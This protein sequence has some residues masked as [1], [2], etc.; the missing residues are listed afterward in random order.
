MERRK[1]DFRPHKIASVRYVLDKEAVV[2]SHEN[3]LYHERFLFSCSFP[4]LKKPQNYCSSARAVRTLASLGKRETESYDV[5]CS[6]FL[7]FL[8]MFLAGFFIKAE[9]AQAKIGEVNSIAVLRVRP[10]VLC[11]CSKKRELLCTPF[12]EAECSPSHP[13]Q[14]S[15]APLCLLQLENKKCCLRAPR[16]HKKKTNK[17][18]SNWIITE[19]SCSSETTARIRSNIRCLEATPNKR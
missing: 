16:I 11:V 8:Q 14:R 3:V 6:S 2:P 13:S 1:G 7:T 17:N 12:T 19:N 9:P 4:L 15:E 18:V 10:K 5:W